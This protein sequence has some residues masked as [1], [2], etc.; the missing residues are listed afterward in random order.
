M[1][2]A[3]P[4]NIWVC[5]WKPVFHRCTSVL[6]ALLCFK[7]CP[8]V[9]QRMFFEVSSGSCLWWHPGKESSVFS[10]C[11]RVKRWL[12][13]NMHKVKGRSD[14][15][16][17]FPQQPS[18]SSEDLT[19][20][21]LVVS[22]PVKQ[23]WVTSAGDLT[24]VYTLKN[25]LN[26]IESTWALVCFFRWFINLFDWMPNMDHLLC[27]QNK[28]T[29]LKSAKKPKG[30]EGQKPSAWLTSLVRGNLAA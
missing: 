22:E 26:N 8:T 3:H 12:S 5:R 15:L 7:S 6:S 11:W 30:R 21:P 16:P 27:W 18:F 29:S 25:N 13:F 2:F 20:L 10:F 24:A 17:V 14:I 23:G 19:W 1:P 4:Q 28:D 9:V